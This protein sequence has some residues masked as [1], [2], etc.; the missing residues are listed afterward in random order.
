MFF[1]QFLSIATYFASILL[2]HQIFDVS[3]ID[4]D[5]IWKF[6]VIT[7]LSWLPLHC[8]K[9]WMRWQYPTDYEKVR[10]QAENSKKT[11]NGLKI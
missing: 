6:V 9:I 10:Q 11:K 2:L 7:V 8:F 4:I 3:Y 1:S 5:F